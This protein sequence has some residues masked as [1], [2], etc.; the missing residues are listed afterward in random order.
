[1]TPEA[2]AKRHAYSR[3]GYD[4][5]GY[6]QVGLPVYELN[7]QAYTLAYKRISPLDEFALKSINAGLS[8][9]EEICGFLG[10]HRNVVRGVLSELIRTDDVAL[11]GSV[12]QPRQSLKLT[13]KGKHTLEEAELI[14]PEERII[15]IQ[16]DGL[17][18]TPLLLREYLHAP[19]DLKSLGWLEIP[20]IPAARPEIDDLQ[21]ADIQR[22]V[23]QLSRYT[24]DIRRDVLAVKDIVKRFKKFRAAVAL[25]YRS[26]DGGVVLSFAIDG[27]LSNEHEEAFARG[28]GL[29]KLK[30]LQEDSSAFQELVAETPAQIMQALPDQETLRRLKKEEAEAFSRLSKAVEKVESAS[31][32]EPKKLAEERVGL[33]E[34]EHARAREAL[35]QLPVRSLSVFEHP[36][37]L[38][39]ALTDSKQRLMIISPWVLPRVID[40][41]F[42]QKLRRLLEGGVRVY[43]GYGIGNNTIHKDIAADL[44]QL[45]KTYSNFTLKK[46]GDTHAKL[47][48]SDK[49]F[50]V[51]GSFNWLSFKGDPSATFRDEQS[52]YVTLPEVIEDKFNEQ[53]KRF[54]SVI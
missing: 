47:L 46:L 32:G 4:L 2:V 29:K 39:R 53:L 12:D 36:A 9:I 6:A 33:A 26:S 34:I 17:L 16:F 31:Q 22:I 30:V 35:N 42:L 20:S 27:R 5:I 13:P 40:R 28:D 15:T 14:S 8:T 23:K 41:S 10:L 3:A 43:I 21:V 18:R 24:K 52:F 38:D 44:K 7:V 49:S 37:L 54:D 48:L 50:V 51:L 1:M 11:S 45:S 19:K 25:R